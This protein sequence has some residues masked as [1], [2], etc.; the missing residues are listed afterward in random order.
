MIEIGTYNQRLEDFS[1]H[2]LEPKS[3]LKINPHQ[4]LSC[5]TFFKMKAPTLIKIRLDELLLERGFS[6]S[7]TQA[8]NM[9]L[10]GKIKSGSRV[11]SKPGKFYLR[12]I[13]L[14]VTE[15]PRYVSRGGDKL[16]GFLE[17]SPLNIKGNIVL[18]IGASV[19]GFTD[20]LLQQKVKTVTCIDVGHNQLH[21]KLL[22]NPRV[23][24]LER[25]N[26]RKLSPDI[27]PYPFYDLITVDLSFISLR[28]V[29]QDIWPLVKINGTLIVLI[30]P[31]F[32]V[33]KKIIKQAK[34]VVKNRVIVDRVVFEVK[35][36]CARFLEGS[37]EIDQIE[38]P[39][40]GADGN[41]EF[42]LSLRKHRV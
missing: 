42:F 35:E 9:I 24:H 12:D 6:N 3:N 33:G 5:I 15:P 16:A 31:Q 21:Q 39:I 37:E 29:L 13:D 34:G 20:Y 36:F 32:E 1:S 28:K 17:N 22:N 19:G 25:V 14:L 7:R 27:L 11:L 26:I 4:F 41:R 23:I 18:D 10:E 30:K 38:S 8:R 2:Y 40:K